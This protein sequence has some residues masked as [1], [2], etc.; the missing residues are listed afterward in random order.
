MPRAVTLLGAS[1]G[2]AFASL[3]PVIAVLLAVP[4]LGERPRPWDLVGITLVGAGVLFASGA[5]LGVPL[6]GWTAPR[7]DML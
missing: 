4:V 2:A 5:R 3:V 6:R 7:R 1:R